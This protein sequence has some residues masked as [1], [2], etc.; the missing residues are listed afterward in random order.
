MTR[1]TR[2]AA[3]TGGVGLACLLAAGPARADD[4]NQSTLLTFSRPVA[5]PGIA[6]G[7][8]T[9]RFEL[10]D[11]NN[12]QLVRVTS[13][14][15]TRIYGTFFTIRAYTADP[16][17][18]TFVSFKEASP[19]NPKPVR[20]WFYPGQH[21]GHEFLYQAV[22]DKAVKAKPVKATLVKKSSLRRKC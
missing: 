9:Y 22:S 15:G 8:G 21:E 14:D 18:R 12:R 17:D 6:L 7:S 1:N 4:W 5:L 13:R 20:T 3:V 2:F 10:P 11:A 16:S 19:R